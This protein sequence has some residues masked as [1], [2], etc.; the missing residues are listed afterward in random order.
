MISYKGIC[1]KENSFIKNIISMFDVFL[2]NC[3]WD[4]F[5]EYFGFVELLVLFRVNCFDV[6]V[7]NDWLCM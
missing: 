6:I 4:W 3:I 2:I 5:V 1:L 7:I